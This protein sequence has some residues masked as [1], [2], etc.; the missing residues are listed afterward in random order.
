M[1]HIYLI[2]SCYPADYL[3]Y[4]LLHKI[5]EFEEGIL[6]FSRPHDGQAE[7]YTWPKDKARDTFSSPSRSNI[8][9]NNFISIAPG[10]PVS[11]Q[12]S[13]GQ[14]KAQRSNHRKV[15]TQNVTTI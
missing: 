8:I 14:T 5:V 3:D 10:H 1:A 4:V 9:C 12:S 11:T 15:K 13:E 2:K 6:Y 7:M